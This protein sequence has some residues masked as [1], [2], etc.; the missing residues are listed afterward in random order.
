MSQ[1]EPNLIDG[2]ILY[3]FDTFSDDVADFGTNKVTYTIDENGFI[4]SL[5]G[6]EE[7]QYYN[8]TRLEH[9]GIF[10][11]KRSRPCFRCR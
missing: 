8:A 4:K 2:H 10:D 11:S 5:E 1:G 9:G 6:D 7:Y 3:G